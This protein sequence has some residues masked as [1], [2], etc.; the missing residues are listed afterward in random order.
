MEIILAPNAGFCYGVKNALK[1]AEELKTDKTVYTYGEL[2][3]NQQE[4]DRLKEKNIIPVDNIDDLKENDFLVIRSH[5]VGKSFYDKYGNRENLIDATCPSVKVAHVLAQKYMNLGY[6]VLVFGDKDHPEV[7]G[8][9]DW[10]GSNSRAILNKEDLEDINYDVPIFLLSQT[11]QS[12]DKFN[13]I[14]KVLEENAKELVVKNTIC[15]ATRNRQ[16]EVIELAKSVDVIIIIGGKQSSNSNKLYKMAQAYNERAYFIDSYQDLNPKWYLGYN[17]VGITAGASTPSWIIE[18]VINKMISED[19]MEKEQTM[20]ELLLEMDND[21]QPGDVVEGI[22]IQIDKENVVVDIGMKAEGIL[23][24]EE[25]ADGTLPN[26][27]DKITAVLLQKSNSVGLPVLSK[28]KLVD[29]KNREAQREAMKTLPTKFENKEEFEGLVTS[30]AKSGLIV[31]I[32]DVE[33]FL[34][35][36][37]LLLN[38]YAKNLDKYLGKKVRVRIIDLDLKK[39]LPKIVLSQKVILSEEREASAKDFWETIE[40]G[41]VVTGEVKMLTDFGAFVNLGYL[42]GLLHVSELSWNRRDNLKNMLAVGDKIN[43]KIIGIDKEKNKISLSLKALEEDPWQTFL[44]S[45]KAGHIIKG[46]VTSV[47]DY[48]AF[49]N[50]GTM[51]EGLL[52]IS[53]IAHEKVDKVSDVLKVGDELEVE[54][55]EIDEVNKKVSLSKKSLEQI[56]KK[57]EP[58]VADKMVYEDSEEGVTLGEILNQNNKSEE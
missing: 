57:T 41:K 47:V 55:L 46:K 43:V 19:K 56:V 49:I 32:D 45:H 2:I 1:K 23:P 44:K 18:E 36:S 51:V 28:R 3:H 7:L 54:I 29:R 37:Q 53:E 26:V 30:V 38:G 48:G 6:Q 14:K 22:V 50:I 25:Y 34:P 10:A 42:D 5:G 9:L 39:R 15:S 31:K 40:V 52:H 21:V 11:T 4:I 17:K 8:I 12:V 58:V 33:G 16:S 13:E 20:E 24:I 35:A 27:G